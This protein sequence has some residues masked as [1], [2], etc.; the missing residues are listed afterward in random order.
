MAFHLRLLDTSCCCSSLM[1]WFS[2]VPRVL[3]LFSSYSWLLSCPVHCSNSSLPFL[4]AG[5]GIGFVSGLAFGFWAFCHL[6]GF[7]FG[8][9]FGPLPQYPSTHPSYHHHPTSPTSDQDLRSDSV[10][11]RRL[12]VGSYLHER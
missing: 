11:R 9:G 1:S 2:Q 12:R 5:I 8:I 6:T 7:G 3:E 4:L 10:V